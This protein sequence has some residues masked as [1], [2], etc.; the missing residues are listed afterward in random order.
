MLVEDN[1]ENSLSDDQESVRPGDNQ[2]NKKYKFEKNLTGSS[3]IYIT[4]FEKSDLKKLDKSA[5]ETLKVTVPNLNLDRVIETEKGLILNL[6]NDAM[7]KRILKVDL[8]KIFGRP[9]QAV[10]LYRSHYKKLVPFKDI[11]WCISKEELKACLRKQ[12]ISYTKLTREQSTVYI[13]VSNYSSYRQLKEEGINFYD[14]VIFQSCDDTY[15][16]E[17]AHYNTDNIIQCYKCQGFWHTANTCKQNIRCVRCGEEHS[18]EHCN[19]PK[20][21]PICCNCKGHHHAAYKLC[22]MRLRLK[23]TVRVAFTYNNQ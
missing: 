12:G 9:V 10:P 3:C 17:E 11:P 2:L 8:A 5:L 15:L 13:E 1:S 22:P 14:S 21:Y 16:N 23:K 7:I 19:R 18:V 4:F 20:S 6:L